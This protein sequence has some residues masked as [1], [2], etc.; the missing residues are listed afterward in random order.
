MDELVGL[1]RTHLELLERETKLRERSSSDAEIGRWREVCA[2]GSTALAAASADASQLTAL[3]MCRDA[4]EVLC[5]LSWRS[6]CAC[7]ALTALVNVSARASDEGEAELERVA[8]A[9][10]SSGGLGAAAS[11]ALAGDARTRE[12]ALMLLQNATTRAVACEALVVD[13]VHLCLELARAFAASVRDVDSWAGFGASLGNVT[14]HSVTARNLLLRKSSAI[15]AA[16]LPHLGAE[17]RDRRL[18]VAV[19]LKHCAV[20][21]SHH[22]YLNDELDAPV[23]SL[24]ALA[25]DE[26]LDRLDERDRVVLRAALGSDVG[27]REPDPDVALALLEALR[28]FCATR[29]CRRRL[30]TLCAYAVIRDTDLAFAP[31]DDSPDDRPADVIVTADDSPEHTETPPESARISRVCADLADM[32]LRD[33]QDLP[34]EPLDNFN[35]VQQSPQEI[36]PSVDRKDAVGAKIKTN[37]IF[38]PGFL[39]AA[40]VASSAKSTAPPQT[41]APLPAESTNYD[42]PD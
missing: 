3:A 1:V 26:S 36:M 6:A 38:K 32:L 41:A 13:N 11:A 35:Y 28:C 20:D 42:L 39:A 23:L 14:A 16:I 7:D 8:S 15:L 34:P 21:P 33:D 30:R 29:R 9:I 24:R 17:S 10:A 12:A 19:S 37:G 31:G 2:L 40:A 18:G 22:Y 27:P 25:D 4:V 5:R